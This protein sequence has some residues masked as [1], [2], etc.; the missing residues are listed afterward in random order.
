MSADLTTLRAAL[1][2][3]V[4][5]NTAGALPSSR[6]SFML[7]DALAEEAPLSL[8]KNELVHTRAHY[9]SLELM[10]NAV[11]HDPAPMYDIVEIALENPAENLI[12]TDREKIII[13]VVTRVYA[14]NILTAAYQAAH[15]TLDDVTDTVT[16][17]EAMKITYPQL[18]FS[19]PTK[20]N[21]ME[22][23]IQK[24]MSDLNAG[25]D[26]VDPFA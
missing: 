20:E 19:D 7:G 6:T 9:D 18:D 8:T 15:E 16:V 24:M 2:S 14:H 12:L 10:L 22:A 21:S 5:L 4:P 26:A 17:H 13:D 3:A 11:A 1:E 25:P 23:F